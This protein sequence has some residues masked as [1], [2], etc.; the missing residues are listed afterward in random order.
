MTIEEAYQILGLQFGASHEQVRA[1][2]RKRARETHPD[3]GGNAQEFIRVQAAYEILC[4]FQ[5]K[6][7]E[8]YDIP[9]PQELRWII[10]QLVNEYQAEMARQRENCRVYMSNLREGLARKVN[11]MPRKELAK[12][13]KYF[14]R[15][16]NSTIKAL[17]RSVNNSCN[18]VK[19]RYEN[20]F[21]DSMEDV[22]KQIQ[23][24]RF[25]HFIRSPK[26]YIL[27]ALPFV[28]G[29]AFAIGIHNKNSGWILL[30]GLTVGI[31]SAG[32]MA[33][34]SFMGRFRK[35]RRVEILDIAPFRA[36]RND[37]V[38][39]SSE[40]IRSDIQVGRVAGIGGFI[41][42]DILTHGI[43]G[44]IVGGLIGWGA[45]NVVSRIVNPTAKIK[46]G[47][48][49]ELD[50]F[51]L[52]VTPELEQYIMQAQQGV[53]NDLRETIIRN[54]KTRVQKMAT[55]LADSANTRMIE[56]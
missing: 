47:I 33:V 17:C 23:I 8:S 44:P 28:L 36:G 32:I 40:V 34:N 20:W 11:A 56:S 2:H 38:S 13:N 50:R 5:G 46:A 7:K 9:V 49:S 22:H 43:A 39:Y 53:Y 45:V 3:A 10:D 37:I 25:N 14:R 27:S 29:I 51:I 55:M 41:L 18:Q 21:D 48:V 26:Y 6:P 19:E 52:L 35:P 42:G 15:E 12:F 16:W 31:L 4:K 24:D 1:A 30:A 54:Y